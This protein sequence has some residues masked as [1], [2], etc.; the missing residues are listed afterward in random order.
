[1][2]GAEQI[3]YVGIYAPPSYTQ[4]KPNT[5]CMVHTQYFYLVIG[6]S[7]IHIC[8]IFMYLSL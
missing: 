2:K 1:M 4:N 8:E 3:R 6:L 7:E 5:D